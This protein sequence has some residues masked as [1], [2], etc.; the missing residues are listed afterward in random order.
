MQKGQIT[1]FIVLGLILFFAATLVMYYRLLP[2]FQERFT[3]YIE[4]VPQEV[5]PVK[6]YVTQCLARITKQAIIQLAKNG[7][8][9]NTSS[10][11]ITPFPTEST[12][13]QVTEHWTVP[14]WWYLASPNTCRTNCNF[15][16]FMPKIH[17]HED[18]L[19]SAETQLE[20][21]I[22]KEIPLCAP[23][24][25]PGMTISPSSP[26]LD[27]AISDNAVHVNALYPMEVIINGKKHDITRFYTKQDVKLPAL[28]AAAEAVMQQQAQQ[29]FLEIQAME[30]VTA[31]SG[32]DTKK[33]PPVSETLFT[34]KPV[35]WVTQNVKELLQNVLTAYIPLL[36]IQGTPNALKKKNKSST[37]LSCCS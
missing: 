30:L 4:E 26:H 21:F 13:L 31:H 23:Y 35:I 9:L 33:L 8:M 20:E 37:S 6:E 2:V 27:V 19:H 7:G 36:R 5:L 11:L 14:Y 34:A 3:P 22:E 12:A 1:L 25:S 24:P 28:Y 10:L 32:L 18:P 17:K 16:F 15:V 29:R